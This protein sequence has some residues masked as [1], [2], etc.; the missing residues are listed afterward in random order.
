MFS[1]PILDAI[2]CPV[3]ITEPSLAAP[4]PRIVYVNKAFEAMSGYTAEELK[5]RTPRVLQGPRTDPA[6][7]RRLQADLAAGRPFHGEAA[8]YRKD[9]SMYWVEW[10]II[11]LL[12][13]ENCITHWLSAQAEVSERKRAEVTLLDMLSDY[14][15]PALSR[16]LRNLFSTGEALLPAMRRLCDHVA[17]TRGI[18]CTLVHD[19]PHL[20]GTG[21]LAIRIYS[22]FR[23]VLYEA[24]AEASGVNVYVTV[25]GDEDEIT[26]ASEDEREIDAERPALT[27]AARLIRPLGGRV[28]IG[29]GRVSLTLPRL[30]G[31]ES[32]T[33]PAPEAG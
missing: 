10:R 17:E 33:G 18:P 4:G 19:R 13:E 7:L 2:P 1:T 11:P 12:D 15:S 24:A 32:E 27:T 3:V 5:G 20:P 31:A 8:N 23:E 14:G 26:V 21:A 16:T 6:T 25:L 30:V 9:G 22:A 28:S 29:N